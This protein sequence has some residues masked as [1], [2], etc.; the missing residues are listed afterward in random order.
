V[1][2][3]YHTRSIL[4]L[5]KSVSIRNNCCYI[6]ARIY[7]NSARSDWSTYTRTSP[8]PDHT[9][10][11]MLCIQAIDTGVCALLCQEREG[12]Y[13]TLGHSFKTY[14]RSEKLYSP[15]EQT[16]LALVHVVEQFKEHL[17][18]HPIIKV[19]TTGSLDYISHLYVC[20]NDRVLK[21]SL[22][23]RQIRW[24]ALWINTSSQS[25]V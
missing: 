22:T 24:L 13:I 17:S 25:L 19:R 12:E 8:Q 15:Q 6:R 1:L 2:C 21:D 18:D 11:F 3:A 4:D 5:C 16:L 20:E 14:S 7:Y 10:P 23:S 9:Q